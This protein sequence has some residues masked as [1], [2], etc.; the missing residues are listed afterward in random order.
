MTRTPRILLLDHAIYPEIY[1]PFDH[2]RQAFGGSVSMTRVG[3]DDPLPPLDG[4]THL[5]ISGSE[6]SILD[7]EP[8][9]PSRVDLIREA[10]AR[11]MA[12]LGSCHGHQMLALA[13]GGE[14][15]RA[16]VPEM[17]WF[18]L[19][20]DADDVMFRG[21]ARPI[22]VFASHFDEVTRAPEGYRVTS[23]TPDCGIHTFRHPSLPIWGV[24]A[25]PEIDPPTG[26]M[27]IDRFFEIDPARCAA[28]AV[29]RPERDSL[30]IAD[31][32]REFLAAGS[33]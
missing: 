19:D 10:A 14:V 6:A 22:W 23:R 31:L 9:V 11:E 32:C 28:V 29:R 3:K 4:F 18:L 7:D 30:W 8:W 5:V 2:W 25:H 13:L 21:A 33:V 17:G 24:Q 27:L 16:A 12:I 15:G 1:K 20:A 26:S